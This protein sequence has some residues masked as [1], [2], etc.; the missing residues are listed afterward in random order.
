MWINLDD[1]LIVSDYAKHIGKTVTWTN[2]LIR[3]KKVPFIL[4]NGRKL[5]PKS[6]KLP[7]YIKNQDLI[8]LDNGVH[9]SI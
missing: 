2:Q 1:F 3:E 4:H 7:D 6:G 8:R 9:K 5:V